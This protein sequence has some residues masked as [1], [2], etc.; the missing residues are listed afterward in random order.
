MGKTKDI[1]G[2]LVPTKMAGLSRKLSDNNSIPTR[3][4]F[5]TKTDSSIKL[6]DPDKGGIGSSNIFQSA[7]GF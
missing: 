1:N 2:S 3:L 7:F 4:R 6:R 5:L